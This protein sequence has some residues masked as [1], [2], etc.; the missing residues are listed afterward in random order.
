MNETR[1]IAMGVGIVSVL[2]LAYLEPLFDF[3][4]K[5]YRRL[6]WPKGFERL[7]DKKSIWCGISRVVLVLVIL[8]SL[9]ALFRIEH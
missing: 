1:I 8:A 2:V 7:L 5:I 9:V 4:L 3:D 6:G